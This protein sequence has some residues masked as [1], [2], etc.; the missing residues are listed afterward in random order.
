MLCHLPFI[1]PVAG[2]LLFAVLPFQ[3]ALAIYAPIAL[4]A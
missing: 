3:T 1:V 2:L 4:L